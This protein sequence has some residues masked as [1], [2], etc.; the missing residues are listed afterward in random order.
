MYLTGRTLI[1]NINDSLLNNRFLK[2]IAPSLTGRAGGESS[3]Y[4]TI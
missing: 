1:H 3:Y 4:Y 2:V